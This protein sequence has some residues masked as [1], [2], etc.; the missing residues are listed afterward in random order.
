[1]RWGLAQTLALDQQLSKAPTFPIIDG[2]S[3]KVFQKG[4]KVKIIGSYRPSIAFINDNHGESSNVDKKDL[5]SSLNAMI[6]HLSIHTIIS[7]RLAES[8]K[9]PV[10]AKRRSQLD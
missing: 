5:I 7:W 4:E 9:D 3:R 8:V 6:S 2:Y 1:M 10:G